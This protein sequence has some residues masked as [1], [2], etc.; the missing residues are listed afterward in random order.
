MIYSIFCPPMSILL[1]TCAVLQMTDTW[2]REVGGGRGEREA[3]SL[4]TRLGD[5]RL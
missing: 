5:I 3:Q 2:R 1:H 4:G